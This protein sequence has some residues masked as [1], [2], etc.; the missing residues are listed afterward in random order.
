LGETLQFI[1]SFD[2]SGLTRFAKRMVG[3]GGGEGVRGTFQN[4]FDT[5]PRGYIIEQKISLRT[6]L[7]FIR[8]GS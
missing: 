1:I 4:P 8:L 2:E 6:L 5:F 3:R 7:T